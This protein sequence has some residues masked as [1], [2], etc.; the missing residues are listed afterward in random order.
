[1]DE[2]RRPDDLYDSDFVR[3]TEE[4]AAALRRAAAERVNAPLD[5]ENLAEEIESLGRSDRTKA[6]SLT[7]QILVHL[8]KLRFSP[9]PDPRKVW[10]R[11]LRGYRH[12]LRELLADSPSLSARLP[13]IVRS[14]LDIATATADDEL[15]SWGEMQEPGAVRAFL[16]TLPSPALLD[17]S[18]LP[19]RP[20]LP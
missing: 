19:Q 7:R 11:E 16:A 4:Q 17:D 8:A 9:A 14:Q 12:Q 20:D 18:Y 2:P 3:W 1:M 5:W 10:A 6:V 15:E 13:D